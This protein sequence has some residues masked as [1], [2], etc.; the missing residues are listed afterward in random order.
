VPINLPSRNDL[1][2]VQL[3][4]SGLGPDV[5]VDALVHV[6]GQPDLERRRLDSKT[7]DFCRDDQGDDVDRMVVVLS[8]HSTDPFPPVT[9]SFKYRGASRCANQV[10]GNLSVTIDYDPSC[11]EHDHWTGTAQVDERDDPNLPASTYGNNTHNSSLNV[12]GSWSGGDCVSESYS[13]SANGSVTGLNEQDPFLVGTRAL[14]DYTGQP[15]GNPGSYYDPPV[16]WLHMNFRGNGSETSTDCGSRSGDIE[17]LTD[18]IIHPPPGGGSGLVHVDQTL[19]ESNA[20]RPENK[21]QIVTEQSPSWACHY[22]GGAG[23][24]I[25]V[26]G[27]VFVRTTKP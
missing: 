27:D 8:N 18:V 4:F 25:R 10:T 2:R 6:V 26:T 19:V 7:L 24:T 11:M 12:T 23:G 16:I 5:D 22:G 9:K 3:D 13:G 20:P 17:L 1:R 15:Q 21:W 14:F